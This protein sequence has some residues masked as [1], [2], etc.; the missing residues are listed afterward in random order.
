[1]KKIGLLFVF[2]ALVF[3]ITAAQESI[4]A[5]TAGKPP[6]EIKVDLTPLFLPPFIS[7][8]MERTFAETAG[9]GLKAGYDRM[10]TDRFSAGV[11]FAFIT[12]NIKAESFKAAINSVDAG[13]HGRFYP[14][15]NFFYLQAGFGIVSFNFDID[16]STG[17]L[18]QFKENFDPYTG[19]GGTFDIGFGFRWLIGRHFIVDAS[20]ISGLYLGN[21]ISAVTLPKLASAG[22]PAASDNG[23]P[24]RLD[25]AIAFGWAF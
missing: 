17:A 1:M 19:V 10:I 3:Q 22:I 16:G 23:F 5:K 15:I 13:I 24:F 20:I 14:W 8:L 12:V 7:E 25:A 11:E 4:F 6:N 18:D 21:T 9:F 2:S